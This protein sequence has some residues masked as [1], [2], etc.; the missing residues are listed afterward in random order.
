MV[1][2]GERKVCPHWATQKAQVFE[3]W[4]VDETLLWELVSQRLIDSK[5]DARPRF[6]LTQL[7]PERPSR[8]FLVA[9]SDFVDHLC[10][11]NDSRSL[12]RFPQVHA[13]ANAN[14]VSVARNGPGHLTEL[15]D[16]SRD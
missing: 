1:R 13:I 16:G 7:A 3:A 2:F 6:G 8:G 12:A 5:D 14:A 9:Y 4:I 11:G 15:L 10:G